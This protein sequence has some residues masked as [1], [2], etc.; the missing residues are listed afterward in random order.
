MEVKK[1]KNWEAIA[2]TKN[3]I[4]IKNKP[5]ENAFSMSRFILGVLE[6]SKNTEIMKDPNMLKHFTKREKQREREREKEKEREMIK[7]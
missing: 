4:S 3:K 1:K 5:W 7:M 2:R 6:I